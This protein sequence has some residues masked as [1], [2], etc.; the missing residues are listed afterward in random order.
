MSLNSKIPEEATDHLQLKTEGRRDRLH[1]GA[2]FSLSR[3]YRLLLTSLL[4]GTPTP[5]GAEEVAES[6]TPASVMQQ[7]DRELSLT[8]ISRENFENL[9]REGLADIY[10]RYAVRDLVPEAVVNSDKI[11]NLMVV[12]AEVARLRSSD[13][14]RQAL[15][16]QIK[17]HRSASDLAVGRLQT[18]LEIGDPLERLEQISAIKKELMQ[19]Y[20]STGNP[21]ILDTILLI[22]DLEAEIRNE[23]ITM[24][25]PNEA[26]VSIPK[27]DEEI[28]T[29]DASEVEMTGVAVTV[30]SLKPKPVTSLPI[31]RSASQEGL[32]ETDKASPE[33]QKRLEQLESLY[34]HAFLANLLEHYIEYLNTDMREVKE[35]RFYYYEAYFLEMRKASHLPLLVNNIFARAVKDARREVMLLPS[36]E[37]FGGEVKRILP[38]IPSETMDWYLSNLRTY[39]EGLRDDWIGKAKEISSDDTRSEI[40]DVIVYHD[41]LFKLIEHLMIAF[42]EL[43]KGAVVSHTQDAVCHNFKFEFWDEEHFLDVYGQMIANPADSHTPLWD[44]TIIYHTMLRRDEND[45]NEKHIFTPEKLRGLTISDLFSGPQSPLIDDVLKLDYLAGKFQ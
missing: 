27:P 32:P 35:S 4:V 7:L 42:C 33:V 24:A 25:A 8:Q 38:R 43:G 11:P 14:E 5:A 26:P 34:V 15:L 9:L 17:I 10:L 29:T 21:A 28:S 37:S 16:E 22:F 13:K 2:V 30:R 19:E 36:S 3:I 31:A 12:L 18:S 41:Q 45:P 39:K 23:L 44:T 20:L 6:T 1:R 40:E